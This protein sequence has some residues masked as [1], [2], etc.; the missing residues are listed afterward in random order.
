MPEITAADR[1]AIHE[2][3]A[4]HGHVADDRDWDR[5][6]E[7]FTDDLVMDLEDFGLGSVRG[8]AA[9]RK[10]C[11]DNE[12]DP[13]QPLGHHVT[14]IVVLAPGG[15]RVRARSKGLSVHADGSS[16]TV[17]YEDALRREPQ[18]WRIFHR[19]VVARR[20]GG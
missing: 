6:G 2:T 11:R 1:I 13:T 5:W 19:K 3:I 17:V 16:G 9:L 20:A 12:N 14:N 4:L 7:L 10:L 8:L 18:G 15:D